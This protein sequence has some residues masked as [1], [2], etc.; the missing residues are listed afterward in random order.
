M[1]GAAPRRIRVDMHTHCEH[2]RD[3]RTP[4]AAQAAAVRRAGLAVICATDHDT[5]EGAL[6][7]RELADGFRVVVGQEVT[8]LDGDIVGLFLERQ[9]PRGLSAEETIHR[10]HEQG[11]LVSIPHPFSRNRLNHIRREALERIAATID[12]VEI[13]NARELTGR[14]NR[15]AAAWAAEHGVP[16]VAGSDAHRTLELGHAWVEMAD[17]TDRD[18]FLAAAREGT[19]HGQL[20][21]VLVHVLTR[22]DKLMN[23]VAPRVPSAA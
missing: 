21:G 16:G 7:L 5:I 10:I 20:T 13:F 22:Y 17:F 15:R 18:T 11:G 9:V 2:S 6:R 8:S 1:T 3:S 12:L 23:K 4:V 19:V 14:E